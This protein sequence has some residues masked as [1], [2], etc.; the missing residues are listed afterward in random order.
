MKRSTELDYRRRISR[1]ISAIV[2]DPG[3]D[4]SV[5][6]LAEVAHFSPFHFHRIYRAVTG[7]SVVAT[8]RRMRLAQASHKL[9]GTPSSVILT[10]LEAGYES[11]QSFARAFREFTGLSPTG[12]QAQQAIV[13]SLPPVALTTASTMV[14]YGIWHD[15]PVATIPHTFRQLRNWAEKRGRIW[16]DCLRF[17]AS[18]GDSEQSEGFRYFAGMYLPESHK[19]PDDLDQ[20]ELSGG[21]FASYR[22]VGPYT[23]ISS[24]LQTLFGGWL[25]QSGLE[26][27]HRPVI[28]IYRNHPEVV[29]H[30]NLITDLLIPVIE[31]IS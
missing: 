30:Q 9:A 3:A 22:L 29:P 28:E 5:E 18:F 19:A 24:T 1:V 4:H 26:P 21:C 6:R 16:P 23:L 14:V 27:D 2:E 10:A 11:P 15:G 8:V 25:P 12:F 20:C 7:E 31:P 13:G 17:G